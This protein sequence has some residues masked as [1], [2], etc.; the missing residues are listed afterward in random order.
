MSV[1]VP[2]VSDAPGI[3]NL[4]V[5]NCSA[6]F[7]GPVLKLVPI[8]IIEENQQLDFWSQPSTLVGYR[9]LRS[10]RVSQSYFDGFGGEELSSLSIMRIFLRVLPK[11]TLLSSTNLSRICSIFYSSATFFSS[12]DFTL[13]V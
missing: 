13:S 3:I 7:P 9:A 12:L 4:S 8:I 11:N 1:E 5:G 2:A 10:L 6:G